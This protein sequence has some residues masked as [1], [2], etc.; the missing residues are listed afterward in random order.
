MLILFR[1]V[2]D[3]LTGCQES[4]GII[5]NK[6]EAE[7][8]TMLMIIPHRGIARKSFRIISLLLIKYDLPSC[9]CDPGSSVQIVERKSDVREF[10]RERSEI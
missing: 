3:E 4:D 5:A 1:T 8:L 7:A 9:P 10:F 2:L 6:K